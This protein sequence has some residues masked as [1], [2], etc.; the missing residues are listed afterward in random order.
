MT[1]IPPLVLFSAMNAEP[2]GRVKAYCGHYQQL[3][4][5]L[6]S[7]ESDEITDKGVAIIAGHGRY[8]QIV[9]RILLANGFETA[10]LDHRAELIDNL[11]KFDVKVFY[12][13]A[14]RP[15]LLHAAG[16]LEA[17]LLIVA[18]D[19]V[20]Q[21]L[22]IIKHARR[23][24]PDLHI[25]ARAHDRLHVF[26]LYQSGANDIVREVFDSSVRT[27]RYALQALGLHPYEA[28]KSTTVFVD[29]DINGLRR[30]AKVWR[31]DVSIFDNEPYM[32][33]AKQTVEQLEAAMEA[34]RAADLYDRTDREWTPPGVKR[35]PEPLGRAE[36][37]D[38]D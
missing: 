24:N 9:N 21:S 22:K 4:Q 11:R 32:K 13:G 27:A 20:E 28:E 18:I 35:V 3:L 1:Y 19:D 10:V 31:S 38:K 33:L 23:E 6:R 17:H 37:K 34:D 12:G 15:D 16:L 7:N 26:E 2:D 8:G 14:S 29:H 36:N 30:L 25:I 5:A